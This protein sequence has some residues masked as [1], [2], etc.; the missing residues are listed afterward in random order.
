MSDNGNRVMQCGSPEKKK[1]PVS[2]QYLNY[3]KIMPIL[4]LT[5]LSVY[6][7]SCSNTNV[8]LRGKKSPG[9][10]KSTNARNFVIFTIAIE[11]WKKEL[12]KRGCNSKVKFAI[13]FPQF[14]SEKRNINPEEVQESIQRFCKVSPSLITSFL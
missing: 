10:I 8:V 12:A 11:T 14:L 2:Y 6:F 3:G 1:R 13:T 9:K 7:S 4:G 5:I